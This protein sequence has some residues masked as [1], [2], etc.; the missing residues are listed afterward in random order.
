MPDFDPIAHRY[1]Q[2]HTLPEG[3]AASVREAIRT[4]A[5]AD[6]QPILEVGAG[7]GRIGAA[8]VAAGDR[9]VGVDP[10][11]GMLERFA[12]KLSALPQSRSHSL[13]VQTD[14][15]T[16]P[17]GDGAF[18]A[19]L[20]VSVLSG[21]RGWRRLLDESR[22]VIR[23][24]GMLVLGHMAGPS[25]GIDARMKGQLAVFL[26]AMG[27]EAAP[28]GARH[29]EA[30]DRLA[31]GAVQHRCACAA[32]W[33]VPRA[34]RDFLTRHRTGARFAAL[35]AAIQDE[36]LGRLAEWARHSF[37]SLDQ[38]SDEVHSF[39]LDVFTFSET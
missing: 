32:R 30:R 19:V 25:H 7:T 34:P 22:R 10:S 4:A 29:D 9:Y 24:G 2:F 15:Q 8:F 39:E 16:L 1:D 3:V 14:G 23:P 17:F 18:G 27:V 38:T 12:A 31:E 20:L 21:V 28:R 11:R 36:A 37:G 35:P 6:T 26:A 5:G 33:V 13:L